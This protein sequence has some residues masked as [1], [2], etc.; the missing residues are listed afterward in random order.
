M[1]RLTVAMVLV[2]AGVAGVGIGL[3]GT[4]ADRAP[5]CGFDFPVG[6]PD[7]TGYYDAQPFGT[8][9]HLGA[10]WN[11]NGGSDSDLGAFVFATADGVVTEARDYEGGWGNVVRIQHT[12]GDRVE[13]LYAHLDRIWV[14]PG[15]RVVRGQ[16]IGTIGNA[17]GR[18]PAHL[19]FEIRDRRMPLGGGYSA[20]QNGYL[21]PTQYIIHHRPAISE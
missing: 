15:G 8:N 6:A 21:D 7:A 4:A 20:D 2:T 17:H 11:G 1:S 14:I 12:C 16:P 19:H 13:S 5:S 18:Y 3:S 10:D 9:H